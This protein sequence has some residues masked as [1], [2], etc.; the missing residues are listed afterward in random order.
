MLTLID[1]IR[2]NDDYPATDRVIRFVV[3][4]DV[5]N[6]DNNN[7]IK[8][9]LSDLATP[10]AHP[11]VDYSFEFER[12]NG[13]WLINGVGFEDAK[14]R[15][16]AYPKRG[17]V[18]RWRLINKSGGALLLKKA[19]MIIFL[20]KNR[21]ESSNSHSLGRLPSRLSYRLWPAVC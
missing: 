16:L 3:G 6:W 5:S 12:K 13:E 21:L 17:Q 11:V 10:G 2:T 7:E 15:I 9:H 20:L 14:N 1:L 19:Q 8:S 18:S 4:G